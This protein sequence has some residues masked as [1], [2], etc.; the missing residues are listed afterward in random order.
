MPIRIH[1]F[2]TEIQNSRIRYQA[3]V[4]G[5]PLW[6][7]LDES[8]TPRSAGNFFVGAVL[9]HA[10]YEGQEIHLDESLP[11]STDY[12]SSIAALQSIYCQWNGKLKQVSIIACE[13]E[14]IVLNNDSASFFS[15]GID[16][17]Y[18]LA[19]KPE[20]NFV[21][22]L[23]SFE[24]REQPDAWLNLIRRQRDF[25]ANQG[26]TLLHIASNYRQLTEAWG[27][28]HQFQ[29]G[30]A[31]GSIATFLG[32]KNTYIPS[33]FTSDYLF[34]WGSHP[35]TDVLWSGNDFRIVHHGI[36]VSR[37]DK[38]RKLADNPELLNNIQVCWKYVDRNCG[39]C[40]KCVRTM[41]ALKFFSMHSAALPE[42]KNI[43]HIADFKVTSVAAVPFV[44]ELAYLAEER[45]YEAVARKLRHRVRRFW[46][47]HHA[48]ELLKLLVGDLL[49]PVV[50]RM[51]RNT[52]S[53]YKVHVTNQQK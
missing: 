28:S 47:K 43:A 11:V 8:I 23:N 51:R 21:L 38:T 44:E 5:V 24:G 52:W 18:T 16:G 41:T 42:L 30:I 31:L 35:L 45:G 36:D 53:T 22:C 29:H 32:F 15:G 3:L 7:E 27:V 37:V 49:G 17:S 48:D 1:G 34:P 6:I 12:L 26:K 40:H 50:R 4:D 19:C 10:M 46:I 14:D 13:K 2:S 20:I 25:L 39:E 33:S 9:L